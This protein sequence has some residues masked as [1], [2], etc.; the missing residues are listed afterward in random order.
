MTSLHAGAD[1][2]VDK[3]FGTGMVKI[4][5][6][7]D[8]NDYVAGKRHGLEEI[9]IFT[10]DAKTLVAVG[11]YAGTG[12]WLLA[13]FSAAAAALLACSICCFTIRGSMDRSEGRVWGAIL[14]H[15]RYTPKPTT[16]R[17]RMVK[18]IFPRAVIGQE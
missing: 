2:F 11:Q 7:H 15:H 1:D 3:A 16:A 14:S 9:N 12:F 6:A 17:S 10:P 4:T 13:S 18:T 5:P 8:P